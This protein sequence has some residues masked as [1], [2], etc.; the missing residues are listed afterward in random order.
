MTHTVARLGDAVWQLGSGPDPPSTSIPR[1][2]QQQRAQPQANPYAH[3][4]LGAPVQ[5]QASPIIRRSPTVSVSQSRL[6]SP[7][8]T[9]HGS[10]SRESS[11]APGSLLSPMVNTGTPRPPGHFTSPSAIFAPPSNGSPQ[12]Q[13]RSPSPFHQQSQPDQLLYLP[14]PGRL[15]KRSPEDANGHGLGIDLEPADKRARLH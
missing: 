7:T 5:L 1:I 15:L 8:N 3:P 14:S 2:V 12:I 13:R 10:F 6:A 11:V 4:F 9:S